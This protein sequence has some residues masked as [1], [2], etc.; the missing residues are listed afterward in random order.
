MPRS[1]CPRTKHN[2][3]TCT[4]LWASLKLGIGGLY[5]TSSPT[6]AHETNCKV[7]NSENL[8]REVSP[9]RMSLQYS[10]SFIHG[11]LEVALAHSMEGCYTGDDDALLNRAEKVCRLCDG[12]S[13][14][15]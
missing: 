7:A 1:Q 11:H 9:F 13:Q 2:G 8:C 5:G 15:A 10:T 4:G 6:R 14:T 3:T 12:G